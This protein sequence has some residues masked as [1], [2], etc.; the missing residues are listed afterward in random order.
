MK[1]HDPIHADHRVQRDYPAK[2]KF[3]P[4]CGATME[5]RMLMP[6]NVERKVCTRCGFVLF[7]GPKL[8]AGCFV[9]DAGASGA[10]CSRNGSTFAIVFGRPTGRP[11]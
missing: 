10:L 11:P 5:S 8:V 6:E 1:K 3:C 9:V 7:P 4:L 2:V